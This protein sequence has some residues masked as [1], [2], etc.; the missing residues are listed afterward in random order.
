MRM[1]NEDRFQVEVRTLK[2]D[3][4]CP[5]QVLFLRRRS[6][7]LMERFDV[8]FF[9]PGGLGSRLLPSS[10]SLLMPQEI[11]DASICRETRQQG[12]L[13]LPSSETK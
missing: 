11:S 9:H 6:V 1:S 12:Q 8:E 5:S 7:S 4:I 2:S 3:L 13:S 10:L